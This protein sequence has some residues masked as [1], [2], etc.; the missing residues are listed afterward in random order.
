MHP[1][2]I[3]STAQGKVLDCTKKICLDMIHMLRIV[4][5]YLTMAS[6][7]AKIKYFSLSSTFNIDKM[8]PVKRTSLYYFLDDQL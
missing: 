6:F 4:N 8:R 7:Y 2:N 5:T 3:K 1:I